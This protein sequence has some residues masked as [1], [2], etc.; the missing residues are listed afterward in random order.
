[1]IFFAISRVKVFFRMQQHEN[2]VSANIIIAVT[3][4]LNKQSITTIL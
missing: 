2:T 4:Y 3:I 1:M